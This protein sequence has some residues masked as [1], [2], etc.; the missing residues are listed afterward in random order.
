MTLY[1]AAGDASGAAQQSVASLIVPADS[2]DVLAV[3]AE[4]CG[5]G[6]SSIRV[7]QYLTRCFWIVVEVL[8]LVIIL[9]IFSPAL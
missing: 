7:S 9:N 8:L 3:L 4:K 5:A 1:V 2:S 6:R